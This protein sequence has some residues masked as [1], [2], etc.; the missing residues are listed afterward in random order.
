MPSYQF[1]YTCKRSF[2]LASGQQDWA[3]VMGGASD[4]YQPQTSQATMHA[5]PWTITYSPPPFFGS[6]YIYDFDSPWYPTDFYNAFNFG[7]NDHNTSY[8]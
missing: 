1:R 6:Q 5:E 7:G 4:S 3:P 8:P 2:C